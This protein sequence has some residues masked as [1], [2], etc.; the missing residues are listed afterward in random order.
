MWLVA[1]FDGILPELRA[2]PNWVL[3]DNTKAPCHP[4]GWKASPTDASTW[5]SFTQVRSAYNPQKHAG[6]G[7]VLDGKPHFF[8]KYLH[9]FDWDHC[10]ENGKI[11]PTV[12]ATVNILN[13]SRL[14]LSTSGT[15]LRGFF[16]H[17][18]PLPSRRTKIDGRSVEL[19]SDAHYMITT[20]LAFQ[21]KV[22][23]S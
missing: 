6:V 20:G 2:V 12:M 5:S 4:D 11:D 16:L 10:I 22:V 14:E 17:D 7:F 3:A 23:L 15:G 1:N 8:G 9:G 18:K 13:I 21:N 19:Y